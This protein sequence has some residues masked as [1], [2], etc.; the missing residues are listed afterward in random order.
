MDNSSTAHGFGFIVVAVSFREI[1][2]GH[3][4]DDDFTANEREIYTYTIYIYLFLLSFSFPRNI[5]CI[6]RSVYGLLR[7][8][9]YQ[10]DKTRARNAHAAPFS[11]QHIPPS[12]I[13]SVSK[14]RI[15]ASEP[16]NSAYISREKSP[17]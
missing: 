12:E 16:D 9:I 11:I 10:R 14:S 17:R 3:S 7:R 6:A 4:A 5:R 13:Y 15:F 1:A 2:L 8:D